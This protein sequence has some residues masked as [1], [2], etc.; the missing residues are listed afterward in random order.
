MSY[1]NFEVVAKDAKIPQEKLDELSKSVRHEFPHDEMMYE[2]HLLRVCTAIKE[3]LV[4][5][6]DAIRS[7]RVA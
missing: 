3:G 6:Q 2:L 5:L 4:T 7:E 1:F